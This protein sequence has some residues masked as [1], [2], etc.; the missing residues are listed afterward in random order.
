MRE[1]TR[2]S[3]QG[4]T[5]ADQSQQTPAARTVIGT[6]RTGLT[7]RDDAVM[8]QIPAKYMDGS[9]NDIVSYLLDNATEKEGDLAASVRNELRSSSKVVTINGKTAKLEDSAREYFAEKEHKG[10]KYLNLEIEVASV[11]QGGLYTLLR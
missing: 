7:A 9:V 3:E 4:T 5:G 1:Q 11:Q 2:K 6:I 8:N 10:V